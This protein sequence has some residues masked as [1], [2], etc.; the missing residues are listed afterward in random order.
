MRLKAA[1]LAGLAFFLAI[2]FAGTNAQAQMKIGYIDAQMILANYKE[3]QEADRKYRDFERELER[4]VT[5]RRN[6]L[7]EMQ[8]NY[9]RQSLILTEK[10]KQEEQQAILKKQ[11]E[12]QRYVAE[13]A[14]P[15][16]GTLVQ[17][18]QELSGPVYQKVNSVIQQIA[19]DDGYDFVLNSE[20]MAFA[21]E[22]HNL[23]E[24]VL[25]ALEKQRTEEEEKKA[26]SVR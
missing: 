2:L 7:Q 13:V 21:K 16:K 11:E 19:K 24:K 26:E 20:A 18:N 12:L 14:D 3:F 9:E 22:E 10:R 25:E 15:Q 8:G 17:K 23:T 5:K 1:G 4:E 6:E